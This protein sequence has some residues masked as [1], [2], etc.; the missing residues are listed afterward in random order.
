MHE[1]FESFMQGNVE[2]VRLLLNRF[3][4]DTGKNNVTF[5]E[6]ELHY[7]LA[8]TQEMKKATCLKENKRRREETTKVVQTY[9]SYKEHSIKEGFSETLVCFNPNLSR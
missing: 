5:Q 8:N 2:F 1:T 9:F 4:M 6:K 7:L 3:T